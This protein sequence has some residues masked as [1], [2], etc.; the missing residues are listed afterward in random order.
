MSQRRCPHC[1]TT[2]H[3]GECLR[4]LL[5]LGVRSQPSTPYH[6]IPSSISHYRVLSLLGEGGMGVVYEAEQE[7][8]YRRVAIKALKPTSGDIH[9][10]R[11]IAE[12]EV[13]AFLDHPAIAKIYEAGVATVAY[14]SGLEMQ[15]RFFWI[16]LVDGEFATGEG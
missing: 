3:S 12:Y 6:E 7:H 5:E 1:G 15:S 16:E 8:P 2:L 9:T 10:A 14:P 13:L 11:F 4:C